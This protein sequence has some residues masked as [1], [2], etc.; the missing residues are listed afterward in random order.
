MKN[1][2]EIKVAGTTLRLMDF[3]TEWTLGHTIKANP[4][5]MAYYDSST[6]TAMQEG[7]TDTQIGM[8][9]LVGLANY[10]YLLDLAA[11]IYIEDNEK[12]YSAELHKKKIELLKKGVGIEQDLMQGFMDFFGTKGQSMLQ[13]LLILSGQ[14]NKKSTSRKKLI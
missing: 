3:T 11:M 12:G 6:K 13:D 10:K 14:P 2:K 4:Y 7:L 5:V 8:A 1:Y 9:V